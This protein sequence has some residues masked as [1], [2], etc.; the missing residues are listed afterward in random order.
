MFV[1]TLTF[2][3]WIIQAS[4]K[5]LIRQHIHVYVSLL[6][7]V[8][9]NLFVLIYSKIKDFSSNKVSQRSVWGCFVLNTQVSETADCFRSVPSSFVLHL[10]SFLNLNH[11]TWPKQRFTSL[12]GL[13]Q[14]KTATKIQKETFKNI[15]RRADPD[16]NPW[17]QL[18][19]E[20]KPK[21]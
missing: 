5:K 15:W 19:D 11:N 14:S 13:K 2:D 10:S 21:H 4:R 7:A 17:K 12:T 9:S 18:E 6:S 16:S 1:R 3:P 8:H 20:N